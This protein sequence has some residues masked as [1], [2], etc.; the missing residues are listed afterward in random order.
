MKKK[1]NISA[2]DQKVWEEYLKNP[3]DV[4]DKD[5]KLDSSL[6]NNSRFKFDL[7]GYK[8]LEANRKVREIIFL[9]SEKKYEEILLITGKGIHSNTG[10]DVYVS[11]DLSKLRYSIPD[12]I[13]TNNDLSAKVS[14][15][16]IADKKDGGDG[17]IIIKL[18]K[19]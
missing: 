8:L 9:C 16:L 10:E 11:K 18:K 19:L 6:I 14:K 17:A 13:K 4:L 12:Y 1:E 15:I 7:H 5:S 2:S 3:K